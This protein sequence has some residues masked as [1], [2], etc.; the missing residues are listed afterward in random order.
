MHKGTCHMPK[1]ARNP[2]KG[3]HAS[4]YEAPP[5][6]SGMPRRTTSAGVAKTVNV[7][8]VKPGQGTRADG[9]KVRRVA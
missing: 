6:T 2:M 9:Q 3:G 8:E 1:P 4:A 5:R 7:S